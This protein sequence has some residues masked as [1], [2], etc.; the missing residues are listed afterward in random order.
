MAKIP[1]E[2]FEDEIIHLV[3]KNVSPVLNILAVYL[4]VERGDKERCDRVWRHLTMKI[5]DII[6]R[7]ESLVTLGD[8]NRPLDSI[9]KSYG[10]KL[11]EEWLKNEKVILLNDRNVPTRYDPHT[12]NGS[13]LDLG[14]ISENLAK[15][16]KSFEIDSNKE[17][18]LFSL[19][20]SG[21]DS[22]EKK[23]SDHCAILLELNVN[24]FK[25]LN[26][27]IPVINYKNPK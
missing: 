23:P 9:R 14:I 26:K 21:K 6:E 15:N 1:D 25:K 7:G 18:T 8:Y 17:W 16:V 2:K 20:K 22:F 4:D 19:K 12:G 10:T 11:F 5:K 3:L 13:V 24:S 27:N